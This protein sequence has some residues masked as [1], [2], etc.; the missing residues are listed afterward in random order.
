[1]VV[2]TCGW[3]VSCQGLGRACSGVLSPCGGFR[4]G[5]FCRFPVCACVR[6]RERERERERLVHGNSSRCRVSCYHSHL[7]LNIVYI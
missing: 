1:M 5:I 6:E 2:L 4:V 3:M 7:I